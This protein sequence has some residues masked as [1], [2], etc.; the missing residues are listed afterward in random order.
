MIRS[1]LRKPPAAACVYLIH[2]HALTG[3]PCLGPRPPPLLLVAIVTLESLH[4]SFSERDG[5]WLGRARS[6]GSGS[7]ID[8]I[9]FGT[10]VAIVT[11]LISRIISFMRLGC[12]LTLT[13]D[14]LV[15]I[16]FNYAVAVGGLRSIGGLGGFLVIRGLG[17]G[18]APVFAPIRAAIGIGIVVPVGLP[19]RLG[20]SIFPIG[21]GSIL[22]VVGITSGI[23][24][25]RS[26]SILVIVPVAFSASAGSV[27]LPGSISSISFT[28]RI[29]AVVVTSRVTSLAVP[30]LVIP[31]LVVPTLFVSPLGVPSLVAA[32]RITS[33]LV[34]PILISPCALTDCDPDTIIL[35]PT[36]K[37]PLA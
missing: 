14:V 34:P 6:R 18:G 35:S 30:I 29:G 31:A 20:A 36:S 1:K 16:R 13:S 23:V 33:L 3:L 27:A 11:A 17:C 32:P 22:F 19:V 21:V 4:F 12:F 8:F 7:F 15:S 24:P 9:R 37:Y 2:V 5:A 26:S 10:I 25:I 28:V